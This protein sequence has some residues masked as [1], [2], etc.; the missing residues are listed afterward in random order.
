MLFKFKNSIEKIKTFKFYLKVKW[1]G[2]YKCG[3]VYCEICSKVR[4]HNNSNYNKI[5][6]SLIQ[7]ISWTFINFY[8]KRKSEVTP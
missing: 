6:F 4:L 3:M 1:F 5:S 8:N 7:W 2:E